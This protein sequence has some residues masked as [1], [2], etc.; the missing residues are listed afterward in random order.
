MEHTVRVQRTLAVPMTAAFMPMG[1]ARQV[2]SEERK[3]EEKRTTP[4]STACLLRASYTGF[5]RFERFDGF[6]ES[7]I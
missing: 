6:L 7:I 4:E 5:W 3:H 2:A 1:T